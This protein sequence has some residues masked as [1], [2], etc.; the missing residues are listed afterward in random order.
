MLHT[1]RTMKTHIV[2]ARRSADDFPIE[3][4]LAWKIAQVA[5]DPVE[6]P[7]DTADMIVNRIID[8]ASVAAAS[9]NRRPVANARAQAVAH[10]YAPGSRVFGVDGRF[11]P[12]WAAWANREG[13]AACENPGTTESAKVMATSAIIASRVPVRMPLSPSLDVTA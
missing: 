2:R 10:P 9:V 6:V 3:E 4:H 13:L 1:L 5:T 11:S 8:N 12:E 7:Q